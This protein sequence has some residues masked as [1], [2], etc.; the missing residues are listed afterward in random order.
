MNWEAGGLNVGSLM[1][2]FLRSI[3]W[4]PSSKAAM[5]GAHSLSAILLEDETTALAALCW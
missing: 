3:I 4:L 2:P 1:P 5:V